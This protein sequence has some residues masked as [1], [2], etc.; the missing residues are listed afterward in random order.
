MGMAALVAL[1]LWAGVAGASESRA[2][3]TLRIDSTALTSTPFYIAAIGWREGTGVESVE[4]AEGT[5]YLQPTSGAVMGCALIVTGSGTWS[6]DAACDGFLSG[7]GSDTL[8]LIGFD[9]TLD[10]SPL[11]TPIHFGLV[12]DDWFA[13]PRTGRVLPILPGYSYW[14]SPGSG[15][16]G[17]CLFGVDLAGRITYRDEYEGC[18]SGRGTRTLTLNGVA[19]NVDAR[20]LSTKH[21]TVIQAGL[22][23]QPSDVIQNY[24]LLPTLAPTTYGGWLTRGDLWPSLGLAVGVDGRLDYPASADGWVSGR[25]TDTLVLH[26]HRVEIDAT[27]TAPGSF[28][29]PDAGGDPLDRGVVHTLRLPPVRYSFDSE[30]HFTVR[31]QDG[32]IELGDD[33]GPCASA[34]G[35]RL[36]VGCAPPPVPEPTP[37]PPAS[38]AAAAA[39]RAGAA[40]HRHPD[41][42]ERRAGLAAAGLGDPRPGHRSGSTGTSPATAATTSAA[43]AISR[44]CGSGRCRGLDHGARR[45]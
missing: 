28:Q 15:V 33:A 14:V 8:R 36:T 27:A 40:D 3:H 5:H 42:R 20:R 24:R 34:G 22:S 43:P 17:G 11:T 10:P 12:H 35:T 21:F 26:G 32:T 45:R 29:I 31:E 18:L 25:G 39:A 7:R 37:P 13:T 30:F 6:Y 9:V 2:V 23:R 19:V 38:S 44:T 16:N 4:L 1:A 41:G